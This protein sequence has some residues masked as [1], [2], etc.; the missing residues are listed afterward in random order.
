MTARSRQ[1]H[2]TTRP[3]F[4][5]YS[6]GVNGPEVTSRVV[7]NLS[8]CILRDTHISIQS[9]ALSEIRAYLDQP[10]QKLPVETD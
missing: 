3:S 5:L 10:G 9:L 1:I 2:P 7:W 4:A 8:V 6:A